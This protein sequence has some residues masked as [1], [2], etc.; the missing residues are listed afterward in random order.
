MTDRPLPAWYRARLEREA[1]RR[2]AHV[3][4]VYTPA[5]VR[6]AIERVHTRYQA[7]ALAVA[8]TPAGDADPLG[9]DWRQTWATQYRAWL[10]FRDGASDLW[11]ANVDTAER[12][13]QELDEWRAQFERLTGRDVPAPTSS[14]SDDLPSSLPGL[15]GSFALGAGGVAAALAALAL[16]WG[17]SRV[18]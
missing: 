9:S 5:G 16:I 4:D 12:F 8:Q 18:S 17:L 10:D 14:G 7:L 11:G 6:A 2:A 15:G 13:D 1:S 3:G